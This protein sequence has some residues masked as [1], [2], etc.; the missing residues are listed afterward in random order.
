[1]CL[2]VYQDPSLKRTVA[3]CITAVPC[4]APMDSWC[5]NTGRYEP[6]LTDKAQHVFWQKFLLINAFISLISN[7]FGITAYVLSYHLVMAAAHVP[8]LWDPCWSLSC[9]IWFRF[10]FLTSMCQGKSASRSRRRWAQGAACQCLKHVSDR[11]SPSF[12]P[13]VCQI[14]QKRGDAAVCWYIL[15]LGAPNFSFL[16][17]HWHLFSLFF[18][19]NK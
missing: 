15:L 8:P 4:L 10:T 1:M 9:M 5:L 19:C 7:L 16:I 14:K 18:V 17:T 13:S 2:L 12:C 3:S 6:T 11:L